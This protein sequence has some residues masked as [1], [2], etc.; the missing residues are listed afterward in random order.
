M[1]MR[2]IVLMLASVLAMPN[3]PKSEASMTCIASS[4]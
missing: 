3:Q 4:T 2:L 1:L